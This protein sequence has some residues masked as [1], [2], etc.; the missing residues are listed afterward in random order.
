MST[1]ERFHNLLCALNFPP[2]RSSSEQQTNIE[3]SLTTAYVNL[4]M[5]LVDRAQPLLTA[6]L[7]SRQ[8]S[9]RSSSLEKMKHSLYM[10]TSNYH[11][12]NLVGA[13][14]GYVADHVIA[15]LCTVVYG[16]KNSMLMSNF[17]FA[18]KED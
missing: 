18:P 3:L 14:V 16:Y 6:P 4:D 7:H 10:T 17:T 8:T 11:T 5:T 2:Q 15:A 1:I 9:M 12:V 13:G